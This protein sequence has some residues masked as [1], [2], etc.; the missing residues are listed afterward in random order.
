MTRHF[1]SIERPKN[2]T[3]QRRHLCDILNNDLQTVTDW[4]SKWLVSFNS[5]KTQG[6]LHSRLKG[7]GDHYNIQMSQSTIQDC[8]TISLLGLTVT[9]DM[10]WKPYI[11]SI[12]KQAAQRIGSLYRAK[13]YLPPQT[14]LYLY[15]ATI[16]PLMEYCCHL[17]AGAPKTHLSLLER[18]EKRLKNLIGEELATELQPLSVRRDVASLSLFYRYY[19]GRCSSALEEC[20]PKPK[21][22]SRSTRRG[23]PL[24]CYH[25]SVERSRTEGR[26]GSFFV[27]TARLWNQLPQS[28][29]P[30]QYNIGSFKRRANRFLM[31]KY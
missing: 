17:W 18:V 16:R 20:V 5:S 13:R 7:D 8:N 25:V 28:C 14:I 1:N 2:N 27:R 26:S 29:F 10:S 9:D 24:T 19:F 31:E 12:S 6:I 21:V 11:Q 22:F 4:G 3:Q 15:K 30:E 23:N